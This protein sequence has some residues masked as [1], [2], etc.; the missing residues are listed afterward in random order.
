MKCASPKVLI[1]GSKSSGLSRFINNKS[2]YGCIRAI[3]TIDAAATPGV[4]ANI[5]TIKLWKQKLTKAT[6]GYYGVFQWPYI[7]II[8]VWHIEI[9]EYDWVLILAWEVVEHTKKYL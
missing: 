4:F 8:K 7:Y 9:N 5:S 2:R 1:V 6:L 3:K